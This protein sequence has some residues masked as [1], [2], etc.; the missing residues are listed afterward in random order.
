ISSSCGTCSVNT[1]S[2]SAPGGNITIAA[3][4]TFTISNANCTSCT[5]SFSVGAASTTGG[6]INLYGINL[7]SNSANITLIAN[8]G[9]ANTGNINIGNIDVS[10]AGGAAGNTNA[11]GGDGSAGGIIKMSASG[12]VTTGYLRA[13][14]GGGGGAGNA[15]TG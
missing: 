2:T 9:S 5:S 3:G 1:S 14:G 4:S 10:G 13:Y 15:G 7:L 8:T 11:A 12:N 6:A